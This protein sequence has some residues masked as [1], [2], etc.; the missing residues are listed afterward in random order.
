MLD[1]HQS[2]KITKLK[3]SLKTCMKELIENEKSIEDLAALVEEKDEEI[4]L[5]M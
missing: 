2:K 5:V 1:H 4:T 3:V